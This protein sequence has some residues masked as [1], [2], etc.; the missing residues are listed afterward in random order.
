MEGRALSR[1][2]SCDRLLLATG[3]CRDP[4]GAEIA[5]SFGHTIEPAVPSLFAL[6]VPTAWIRTLPGISVGDVEL[7]VPET[8][9]RER[10][11]LLITHN[12]VSGPAVLRLSAWGARI[13]HKMDYHFRLRVNWI[14]EMNDAA[15]RVE[16][17]ERRRHTAEPA[18][19]Q[20]ASRFPSCATVGPISAECGDCIPRPFGLRS[21]AMEPSALIRELARDGTASERKIAEQRGVRHLRRR[22]PARDQFQNHGEPNHSRSLLCR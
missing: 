12:G 17:Q 16:F 21:D 7:S 10:G 11:A 18:R 14:P 2:I 8:K 1:P 9:L 4:I 19:D 15:L 13:L 22:A 6:H 3:G 5:R 20:F